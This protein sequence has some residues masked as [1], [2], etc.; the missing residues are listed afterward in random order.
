MG[1]G[2]LPAVAA[3]PVPAS[4]GLRAAAPTA[5]PDT[6]RSGEAAGRLSPRHRAE[7]APCHRSAHGR[8]SRAAGHPR[9]GRLSD[10]AGLSASPGGSPPAGAPL[11]C[12]SL[13]SPALRLLLA[14]E[15]EFRQKVNRPCLGGIKNSPQRHREDLFIFLCSRCL[16]DELQ[17]RILRK[18]RFAFRTPSSVPGCCRAGGRGMQASGLTRPLRGC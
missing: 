12:D 10:G 9:E 3:C 1:A 13:R 8:H 7:A 2:I 17:R 4:A 16:C 18:P 5:T 6:H 14:A 15:A 11:S